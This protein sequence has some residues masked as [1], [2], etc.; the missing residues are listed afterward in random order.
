MFIFKY[1]YTCEV[2]VYFIPGNHVTFT[3]EELN[4]IWICNISKTGYYEFFFK[5]KNMTYIMLA[6]VYQF[7]AR[8]DVWIKCFCTMY[9]L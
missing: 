4:S 5:T 9:I 1:I 8:V 3:V 2:H 7:D 6:K